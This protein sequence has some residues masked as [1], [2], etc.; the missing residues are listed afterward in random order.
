MVLVE[1]FLDMR[2]PAILS[3][4]LQVAPEVIDTY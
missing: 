1:E 4:R 3:G 2:I